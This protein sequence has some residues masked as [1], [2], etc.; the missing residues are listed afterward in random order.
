M[1]KC[2]VSAYEAAL[3]ARM[4]IYTEEQV[5]ILQDV[6][7]LT[8]VCRPKFKEQ[9]MEQLLMQNHSKCKV[10]EQLSLPELQ[11][12]ILQYLS[13]QR[14]NPGGTYGDGGT[15]RSGGRSSSCQLPVCDIG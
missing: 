4:V 7:A 11:D 5:E 13:Q 8:Q 14:K 10:R 9:V 1:E 3:E 6:Y 15:G 2:A 12:N